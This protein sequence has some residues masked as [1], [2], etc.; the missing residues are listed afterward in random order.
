[1]FELLFRYN[2]TNVMI[3]LTEL[4]NLHRHLWYY[5]YN[6]WFISRHWELFTKSDRQDFL[7]AF[8]S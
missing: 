4:A 5:V 3:V 1:M 8:V 6:I 7:L 2:E